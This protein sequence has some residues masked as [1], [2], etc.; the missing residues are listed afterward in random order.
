M[1]RWAG[2]FVFGFLIGWRL[3]A[4][5]RGSGF[6]AAEQGRADEAA[7]GGRRRD[8]HLHFVRELVGH[9][10]LDQE[11]MAREQCAL[12]GHLLCASQAHFLQ[13][14]SFGFSQTRLN[15]FIR[16]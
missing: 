1:D 12:S 15:G 4:V 5:L 2:L 3:G 13:A 9:G 6:S 10:F 16:H 7:I 14:I 11:R 8:D